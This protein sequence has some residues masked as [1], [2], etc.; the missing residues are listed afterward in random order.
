MSKMNGI[1]FWGQMNKVV[2]MLALVLPASAL[3]EEGSP[4]SFGPRTTW[5]WNV[6]PSLGLTNGGTG[7]AAFLAGAETSVV[8]LRDGLWWGLFADGQWDFGRDLV[9]SNV[10]PEFGFGPLGLDGGVALEF[11]DE[12]SLGLQARGVLTL[13]ILSFTLRYKHMPDF[14]DPGTLEGG[15]LL[16]FPIWASDD[17]FK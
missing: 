9:A 15:L 13:G 16:K 5:I 8:R 14:Q 6:G 2:L 12:V 4:F 1:N 7:H 17:E 3:A 10:G 11:S